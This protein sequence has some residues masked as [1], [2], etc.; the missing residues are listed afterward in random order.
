[1]DPL[2]L[3]DESINAAED[4]LHRSSGARFRL[5]EMIIN[6]VSYVD[7]AANKRRFLLVKRA[8]GPGEAM[9]AKNQAGDK[10]PDAKLDDQAKNS[11]LSL[12]SATK[13][14]MAEGLT[15]ALGRMVEVANAIKGAEE[16]EE[17]D[18]VVLP[19]DIGKQLRSAV[20]SVAEVAGAVFKREDN[21]A[22]D[23]LMKVAETSMMLAEA[24]AEEG[25]ISAEVV[26]R[27][28]QMSELLLAVADR[29][30]DDTDVDDAEKRAKAQDDRIAELEGQ[31]KALLEAKDTNKADAKD[32]TKDGDKKDD[33]PAVS[34]SDEKL[35]ALVGAVA[36]LTEAVKAGN[37]PKADDKAD[38][39]DDD[40][41][42]DLAKRLE[43]LEKDNAVLKNKLE[44][45][46]DD[47]PARGSS[48]RTPTNKSNGG[49]KIF[50]ERYNDPVFDPEPGA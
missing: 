23:A 4:T 21:Q 1:V 35:D 47:P 44:K 33:P 42:D 17:D 50:P 24:V 39:K 37:Q 32:D 46:L 41:G 38:D 19:I 40:K 10:K 26:A 45:A 31:V 6:E 36:A 5:R 49:R 13:N 11:V 48:E 16:V 20:A 18:K 15:G 14:T 9:G 43:D 25:E 34:K 28:K 12:T 8:S 7:R 2:D 3:L 22:V 30:D 27:T 29:C